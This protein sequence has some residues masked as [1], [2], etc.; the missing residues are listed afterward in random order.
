MSV[1]ATSTGWNPSSDD[2]QQA[3]R[4]EV[5][6]RVQQLPRVRWDNGNAEA[7]D[8]LSAYIREEASKIVHV[9]RT[10]ESKRLLRKPEQ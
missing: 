1:V 9:T 10:S 4:S 6:K 7:L 3:F 2:Q 8:G 5:E